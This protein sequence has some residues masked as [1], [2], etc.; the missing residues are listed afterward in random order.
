[1][2][3]TQANKLEDTNYYILT[4]ILGF[5]RQTPY[6]FLLKTVGISSL[7]QRKKFQTLVLV[8]KCLH[9]KAPSYIQDLFNF[10]VSSYNLTF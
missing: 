6:E 7:E 9:N 10:K 1:V 2:G 4:S 8:Y 3:N 5:G